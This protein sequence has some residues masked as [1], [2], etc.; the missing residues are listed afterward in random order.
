M[1]IGVFMDDNTLILLEKISKKFYKFYAL[2]DISANFNAGEF[3]ALLGHNGAGKS[4]LLKIIAGEDYSSAGSGH[5]LDTR[6][7]ED[8]GIKKELIGYVTENIEYQTDISLEKFFKIFSSFYKN[9]DQEYFLEKMKKQEIDLTRDFKTFSRGQKMQIVLIGQLSFHPKILLIDEITS[10]LD[11]YARKFFLDILSDFSGN[12]GLV[13]MTTNIV[14]ELQGKADRVLLLDKGKLVVNDGVKTI[15]NRLLKV[16]RT[17]HNHDH[18]IFNNPH[19]FWVS[20]NSDG[21]KSY[22]LDKEYLADMAT[23]PDEVLDRREISLEE[24]FLFYTSRNDEI[25]EEKKAA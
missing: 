12:G 3:V 13:I 4:T 18:Y 7:E 23:I 20:T 9:W 16:R 11:I 15:K 10:V 5:I 22:I 19:C 2:Q 25:S 14:H 21:S 24:I 1:N 8:L 17:E 6:F